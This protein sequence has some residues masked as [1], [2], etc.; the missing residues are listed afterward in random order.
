MDLVQS[1]VKL[2]YTPPAAA[3]GRLEP[4]AWFTPFHD[5]DRNPNGDDDFQD[6]D[7]GAAGPLL[8]PDMGLVVGAG[9]DGVLYVLD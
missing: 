2:H 4:I 7:L 1:F 6:Y 3:P 9:K 8:I 5:A